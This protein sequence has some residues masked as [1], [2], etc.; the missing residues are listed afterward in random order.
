MLLSI[1]TVTIMRCADY[2][3]ER[4]RK[5]E[6][7]REREKSSAK[8]PQSQATWVNMALDFASPNRLKV[9]NH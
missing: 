1:N 2:I 6:R 3:E 9:K 5:R 4:E 8:K 7:E